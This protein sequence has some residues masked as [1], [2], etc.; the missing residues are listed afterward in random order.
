METTEVTV[1][2]YTILYRSGVERAYTLFPHLGETE[3]RS[4]KTLHITTRLGHNVEINLGQ[5]AEL[6]RR[7]YAR[8]IPAPKFEPVENASAAE[9]V[10]QLQRK[11]PL[12]AGV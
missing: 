2:D 4:K 5:V 1:I 8:K 3:S 9:P 11:H 6:S 12:A 10:D 7:A